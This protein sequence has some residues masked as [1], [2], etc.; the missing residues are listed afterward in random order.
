M[1]LHRAPVFLL[2]LLPIVILLWAWADSMRAGT[3]WQKSH[4]GS[5]K[6]QVAISQASLWVQTERLGPAAKLD[7]YGAAGPYP[8]N[9]IFGK[10][11]RKPLNIGAS[12]SLFPPFRSDVYQDDLSP[13]STVAIPFWLI[14]ACYLPPWLRLSLWQARRKQKLIDQ[15]I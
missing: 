9:G 7:A 14:L 6:T 4:P 2:G 3:A 1:S 5:H 11:V 13:L 10:W 8:A 12:A 15:S